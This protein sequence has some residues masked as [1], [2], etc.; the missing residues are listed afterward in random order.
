VKLQDFLVE[1]WKTYKVS[2]SPKVLLYDF[3]LLSYISSLILDPGTRKDVGLTGVGYSGKFFGREGKELDEDIQYAQRQLLPYLGTKLAQALFIAVCAELRHVQDKNQPW[4]EFKHTKNKTFKNYIRN[5]NL[6][7][8]KELKAFHPTR[9]LERPEL[10]TNEKGYTTSY[11][12]AKKAIKDTNGNVIDFANMAADAFTDLKWSQA[13]GGP[14][15]AEIAHGYVQLRRALDNYNPQ[16]PSPTSVSA[17]NLIAAI[18]HAFD[19]EHNTGTVLN[20]VAYFDVEVEGYDWIKKA[21]DLKRDANMYDIAKKASSDMRKLGQEVLKVAGMQDKQLKQVPAEAGIPKKVVKLQGFG[22]KPETNKPAF[23]VGDEVKVLGN[24]KVTGKVNQ[25]VQ[26]SNGLLY[27]LTITSSNVEFFPIGYTLYNQQSN[28]LEKISGKEPEPYE[29]HSVDDI[30]SIFKLACMRVTP[31]SMP[32]QGVL[33]DKSGIF[34]RKIID[35][36]EL[37]DKIDLEIIGVQNKGYKDL[38][39]NVSD[40]VLSDVV[41]GCYLVKDYF[42]TLA[43]MFYLVPNLTIKPNKKMSSE[44]VEPGMLPIGGLIK[45]KIGDP[46]FV[47]QIVNVNGPY[48]NVKVKVI[49]VKD[50]KD[51]HELGKSYNYSFDNIG[52][53]F[54]LIEKENEDEI[55]KGFIVDPSFKSEEE[56]SE[57]KT[58]DYVIRKDGKNGGIVTRVHH[59]GNSLTYKI[60][61]ANSKDKNAFSLGNSIFSYNVSIVK[62]SKEFLKKVFTLNIIRDKDEGDKTDVQKYIDSLTTKAKA[63]EPVPRDDDDIEREVENIDTGYYHTGGYYMTNNRSQIVKIYKITD[64]FVYFTVIE[65]KNKDAVGGYHYLPIEAFKKSVNFSFP[66]EDVEYYKKKLDSK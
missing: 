46:E 14:K 44:I 29:K 39:G 4:S 43:S 61:A 26:S 52:S 63:D 47:A 60:L 21:L 16:A 27:H 2:S 48:K 33:A 20:K 49:A 8:D 66:R 28:N 38:L 53:L 62:T 57:F 11:K 23:Q 32:E 35:V 30:K 19:L 3:Y 18:D 15:W 24:S 54:N 40:F 6:M 55:L 50:K 22:K 1:S 58:G 59:S 25:I 51:E 12:A 17:E 64:D 9:D 10:P 7:A 65:S 42:Q 56:T 34:L 31:Q 5:Y 37:N 41:K 13:Y 45:D 36:D